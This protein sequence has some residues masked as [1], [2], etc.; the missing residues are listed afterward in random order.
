MCVDGRIYIYTR[1][2]KKYSVSLK[3]EGYLPDKQHTLMNE[4]DISTKLHDL[5]VKLIHFKFSPA[6]NDLIPSV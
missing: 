1:V 4:D 2:Y 6:L 3:C 5:K